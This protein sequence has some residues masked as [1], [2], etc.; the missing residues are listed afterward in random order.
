MSFDT[1]TFRP[2]RPEDKDRIVAF[3]RN[4]WG[5]HEDDYIKDVFDEWLIDPRG[6]FT[7]AVVADEV[8]GI[9]AHRH[10]RRRDWWLEAAH[11]SGLAARAL[12]QSLIAI[13]SH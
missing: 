11:R 4:T 1:L 13:T 9:K 8:V 12:L 7:A 2:V 6:E 3:T 10:G 5:D